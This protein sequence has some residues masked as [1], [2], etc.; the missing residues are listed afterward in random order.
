M[1]LRRF[2]LS[3]FAFFIG[4]F[5]VFGPLTGAK[6]D[7]PKLTQ[8]TGNELPKVFQAGKK[9]TIKLQYADPAGEEVSKSKALFIDD[10]PSGR[11]STPATDISGDTKTGAFITWEINGFEQGAHHA[12]FEVD[13]PSAKTRF[14]EA[15]AEDYNFVVEAWQTKLL[16]MAIGGL[17]CIVAIPM[18]SYLLFRALNP[19]GDPSRAA[20][21]GL[22][23]GILAAC[24]LFIYLYLNVF[25]LLTYAIL[26]IGLI[27]VIVLTI[28]R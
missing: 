17:L 6:A 27:A 8:I 1:T 2:T 22:L 21:I 24:A 9:Y 18:I 25:G 28:Q 4:A 12:H 19:R 26:I 15:A 7:P 23:V 10:A 11:V 3:L 16:T 13:G 20:R 5:M 14:P